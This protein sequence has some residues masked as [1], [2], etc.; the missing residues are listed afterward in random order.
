[1]ARSGAV[2]AHHMSAAETFFKEA[3][4]EN[5]GFLTYSELSALLH[6]KG[7]AGSEQ[8]VKV[9]QDVSC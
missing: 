7:Y 5:T 4:T 2:P 9:M 3:D 8:Q 6:K 1:M